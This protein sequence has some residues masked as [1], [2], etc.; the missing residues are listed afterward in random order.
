MFARS[1][2]EAGA[3]HVVAQQATVTL[4]AHDI[5]R[6]QRGCA[7]AQAVKAAGQGLLVRHGDHATAQVLPATQG[8]GEG[9]QRGLMQIDG[10]H[11]EVAVVVGEPG[12]E[13]F[14]GLHLGNG[15]TD[16]G[17]QFSRTTN[18]ADLLIG[19]VMQA[20]GEA[21]GRGQ[22]CADR[23]FDAIIASLIRLSR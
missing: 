16:D 14:G 22:Q 8:A 10:Q 15:R 23:A 3:V 11:G 12:V 1:A 9:I 21:R 5:D 13:V 4:T 2:E 19:V 6:A 17:D 18:H 20:K 7:L